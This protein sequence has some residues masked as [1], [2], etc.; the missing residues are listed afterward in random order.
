MDDVA[1]AAFQQHELQ[2]GR[3]P[4]YFTVKRVFQIVAFSLA[5]T[6]RAWQ[7]LSI[8]SAVLLTSLGIVAA[9]SIG[10]FF[11]P[12]TLVAVVGAFIPTRVPT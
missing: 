12:A 6:G 9:A 4:R 5:A 3:G 7:P 8:T 11:A 2:T 1:E 10:C